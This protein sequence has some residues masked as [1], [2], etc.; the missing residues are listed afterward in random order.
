[1]NHTIPAENHVG[2][3]KDNLNTQSEWTLEDYRDFYQRDVAVL[4]PLAERTIQ[5]EQLRVVRAAIRD[6]YGGVHS[7]PIPGRH[8]DVIK[9]MVEVGHQPPIKYEQGF[10]LSDGQFVRRKPAAL[11]A[12]KAGQC[13]TIRLPGQGLLSED[14]W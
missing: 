4:I 3:I 8:N 13:T 12:I 7:V 5:A 9:Q 1:M 14:V 11:I 10:V 6:S 2:W